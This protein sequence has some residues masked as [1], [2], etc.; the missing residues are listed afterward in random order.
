MQEALSNHLR[1]RGA[2]GMFYLQTEE[3]IMINLSFALRF[4]LHQN[5]GEEHPFSQ[6]SARSSPEDDINEDPLCVAV[7]RLSLGMSLLT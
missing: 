6:S 3:S 1:G 5:T 2:F 7:P 4:K